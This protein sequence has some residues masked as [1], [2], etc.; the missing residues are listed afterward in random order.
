[1]GE[2]FGEALMFL[3]K[4]YIVSAQALA[5][6]LLMH[7]GRAVIFS[8]LERRPQFA[9]KM[10]ASLSPRSRALMRDVEAYSLRSGTQR[11]I[12]YLLKDQP[13]ETGHA[14]NLETRKTV[15]A[16]RLNLTPEHFS[17]ILRDLSDSGLI[18]VSGRKVTIQDGV[19]LLAY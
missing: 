7:G 16:S 6:T 13:C 2:C 8:E 18:S 5:D 11:V 12:A 15:I 14:F 19:R 3:E 10:L 1:P 17:R 9:R 4:D